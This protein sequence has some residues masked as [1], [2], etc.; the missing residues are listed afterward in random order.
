MLVAI[1]GQADR[2]GFDRGSAEGFRLDGRD[3]RHVGSRKGG[4]HVLHVPDQSDALRSRPR[5][6]IW[7]CNSA[8]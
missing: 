7:L 6:S 3:D 8:T 1:T 5:R 4:G 2:R